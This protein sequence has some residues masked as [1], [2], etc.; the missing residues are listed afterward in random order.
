M[1]FS[2]QE[3]AWIKPFID[4]V[5]FQRLRHVKQLGLGDSIFPG[6]VHTRFNHA[7]GCCYVASQIA[8]KLSLAEDDKQLVMI[9]GL[10]HDIGHGPFSHAFENI[11]KN[12]LIHHEDWTELFLNDYRLPEFLENYNHLNPR[13]MLTQERFSIIRNLIMHKEKTHQLLA[14]IVSSQ[15]DADRLDYLLRDSHFCGV[16]YGQYDLPWLLNCLTIIEDNHS[17]RLGVTG[18]GIGVV[19]QYLTARRLMLRNVY[20]NGKKYAAEF[21]L[22]M[23]LNYLSKADETD[24]LENIK[25][26]SLIRFLQAVREFNQSVDKGDNQLL[27]ENF[28][29]EN[30]PLYKNLCDYDVHSMI[31]YLAGQHDQHPATELAK[32]LYHRRFPK[33]ININH[34]NLDGAKELIAVLQKETQPWQVRLLELPHQAYQSDKDPILV[35][36]H[37]KVENINV[38]SLLIGGLSNREESLLILCI[39]RSLL[40][41]SAVKLFFKTGI[42]H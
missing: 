13:F 33:V 3:D 38:S 26:H 2:D 41:H 22:T 40:D 25:N 11:F 37:N 7:L 21:Q 20:L 32:R 8:N 27:K 18:K 12:K 1:Q 9:A 17:E 10:L 4:S 34:K 6:A 19:E 15:L 39:D 35:K 31:R 28:L 36:D 24:F 30:Y 29:K 42:S 14:D 16:S 23:F 5:N